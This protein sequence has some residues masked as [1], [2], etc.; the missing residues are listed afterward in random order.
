MDNRGLSQCGLIFILSLLLIITLY[1]SILIAK[2]CEQGDR[3]R[4]PD[5]KT[6][7]K[8]VFID[9]LAAYGQ[10]L[11]QTCYKIVQSNFHSTLPC[12]CSLPTPEGNI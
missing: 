4:K 12:F 6:G 11:W 8:A 10:L 7:F 5:D 9:L 3:H 2:N 1:F